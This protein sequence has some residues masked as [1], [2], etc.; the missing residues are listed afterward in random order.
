MKALR[1]PENCVWRIYTGGKLRGM[2]QGVEREDNHYPE[3]WVGSVITCNNASRPD[4]AGTGLSRVEG[5]ALLRN[6]IAADPVGILGEGHAARFGTD[7]A[8]LVKVLDASTRLAIQAHPTQPD[9]QKYFHS[10]YGKTEA[11]YVLATGE[12]GGKVYAGFKEGVTEE[13]WRALFAAQ[14]VPGMLDCMHHLTVQPGDLILLE[15]GVPHA[16][17]AGCLI[18]EIQEPTDYTL[19]TERIS[20]LGMP[21]KDDDLHQ[22]AGFEAMFAMFRYE[23]LSEE[24]T[25]ARWCKQPRLFHET[26][27]GRLDTLLDEADTPCFSLRRLT[28]HGEY[29]QPAAETFRVV[30]VA[31]GEGTLTASGETLPLKQGDYLFLP[32]ALGEAVWSG[33]MTV[34]ECLPPRV[35]DP[36]FGQANPLLSE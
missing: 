24:A 18:A 5:G 36:F 13:K 35:F 28:V 15:G 14:D 23:G 12:K 6:L 32:A 21:M 30:I 20:P 2:W 34:L 11:W 8:L 25:L 9:A 10:P 29:T 7:T 16:I 1:L 26:P 33:E 19:R 22:G 3:D 27:G 4:E 31:S 17:D